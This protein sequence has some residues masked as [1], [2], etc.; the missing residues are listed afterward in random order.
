MRTT[1]QNRKPRFDWPLE[2]IFL[3]SNPRF[4]LVNMRLGVA[5][6]YLDPARI[7]FIH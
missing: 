5:N 6:T 4:G 7:H 1:S 3:P 2:A